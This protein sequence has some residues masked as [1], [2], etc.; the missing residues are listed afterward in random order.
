MQ[1]AWSDIV[2]S[3]QERVTLSYY[4]LPSYTE[5]KSVS[6]PLPSEPKPNAMAATSSQKRPAVLTEQ[7]V[8]RQASGPEQSL[9]DSDI[10]NKILST[11]THK[12][13]H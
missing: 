12:L 8:Q 7:Q 2:Y 9:L 6:R 10:E 5:C 13:T 4:F 3:F 11:I 1:Q